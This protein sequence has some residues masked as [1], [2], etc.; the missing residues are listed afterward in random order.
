M[1]NKKKKILLFGDP[2][3]RQKA[4][5][6]TVFHNKLHSLIDSLYLTLDSTDDGAAIAAPQVGTLKRIVVIDYDDEY[7]ELINPEIIESGGREIK[8]EGCLSLPGYTGPVPRFEYV[9]VRYYDRNGKETIVEKH[10]N[11]ARCFQ[12]EIDHLDGI[13]FIDRM[14]VQFLTHNDTNKKITLEEAL[15]LS[16]GKTNKQ[17]QL[18]TI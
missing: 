7:Y 9:K 3:L 1:N 11:M 15:D 4:K 2:V 5:P 8:N 6:V 17:E 13:L 14:E 18:T 10:G 16:N 12:H